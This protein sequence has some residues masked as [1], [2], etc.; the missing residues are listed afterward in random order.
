MRAVML[1]LCL[2]SAPALAQQVYKCGA[3]YSDK[4]CGQA[5]EVVDL[6]TYQPSARERA[7]A[8][9][10]AAIDRRDVQISDMEFARR[11]ARA[12]AYA[13]QAAARDAAN[14]MRCAR[15]QQQARNAA[16]ERDM[17]FTQGFKNDADRR[18]KEA[19]DQH[20]S[21]CYGVR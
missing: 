7:M 12:Q 15:I 6:K 2:V 19:E 1:V 10:R 16:N 8:R 13:A 20:F 14:Q 18:R 4:P 5:P 9:E 11:E 21:E 3:V 17:Y